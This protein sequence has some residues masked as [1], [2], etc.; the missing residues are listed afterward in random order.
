MS[1]WE[2]E[3]FTW[4]ELNAMYDVIDAMHKAANR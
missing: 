3:R 1:P 2:L 4:E